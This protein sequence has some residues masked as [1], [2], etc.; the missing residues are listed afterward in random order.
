MCA[1]RTADVIA[2]SNC[3]FAVLSRTDYLE[4]VQ[5]KAKAKRDLKLRA[6]QAATVFRSL[7]SSVIDAIAEC[8]RPQVLG[9]LT[10]NAQSQLCSIVSG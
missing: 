1:Q 4:V 6:V 5:A 10:R 7:P 3:D 8:M 9:R 2:L